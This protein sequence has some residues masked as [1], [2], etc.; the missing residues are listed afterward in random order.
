MATQGDFRAIDSIVQRID[1]KVEEPGNQLPIGVGVQLVFAPVEQLPEGQK[2]NSMKIESV[3]P[4]QLG[5]GEAM[6]QEISGEFREIQP[7]GQG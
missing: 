1:G 3:T 6:S 4:K 2:P 5:V 7:I